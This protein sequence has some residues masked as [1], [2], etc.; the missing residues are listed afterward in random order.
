MIEAAAN[1]PADILSLL[2][3]IIAAD[4]YGAVIHA[5][6][7]G[8]GHARLEV[9]AYEGACADCLVPK[10]VLASILTRRLPEGVVLDESDLIYPVD[11]G[12]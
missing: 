5:W 4:G 8:P 10:T 12:H 3:D 7:D 1:V 9:V 2:N 6:P 11:V